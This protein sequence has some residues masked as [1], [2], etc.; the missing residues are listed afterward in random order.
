MAPLL[1]PAR[2]NLTPLLALHPFQKAVNALAPAIVRLIRP[3]HN[4]P[5]ELTSKLPHTLVA[6]SP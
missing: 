5:S 2:K 1:P 6:D 4:V 3:L